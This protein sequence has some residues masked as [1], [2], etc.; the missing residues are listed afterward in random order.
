[1]MI[2]CAVAFI[3]Q[4]SDTVNALPESAEDPNL[5]LEIIANVSKLA[6][7]KST[8]NEDISAE[9]QNDSV[10]IA[11]GKALVDSAVEQGCEWVSPVR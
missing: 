7:F 9:G 2:L 8:L 11:V 6:E 3:C 10:K 1:M 4:K 5:L